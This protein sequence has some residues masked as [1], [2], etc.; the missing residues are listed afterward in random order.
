MDTLLSGGDFALDALGR[1]IAIERE[2]ELFQ[3]V[4]LRLVIKKGSFCYDTELGSRLYT[5]KGRPHPEQQAL[6]L[7]AEALDGLGVTPVKAEVMPAGKQNIRLRLLLEAN[8]VQR[9]TEVEL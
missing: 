5:L 4:M 2:R 1:P 6:T 7:A 9:E 8:G 3:K